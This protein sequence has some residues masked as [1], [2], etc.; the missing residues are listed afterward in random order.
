MGGMRE[1]I[2]ARSVDPDV[3]EACWRENSARRPDAGGGETFN[4]HRPA[5]GYGV[6]AF[7]RFAGRPF[8]KLARE[9]RR[10]SDRVTGTSSRT[11]ESTEHA[12]R[13][14]RQRVRDFVERTAPRD[15]DHDGA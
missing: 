8:G 9:L 7:R 5:C 13:A 4:E 11:W 10:N 12:A 15:S 3:Q 14:A 1:H 6:D 2:F